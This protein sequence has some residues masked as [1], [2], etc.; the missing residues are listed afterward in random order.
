MLVLKLC[1]SANSSSIMKLL[2]CGSLDNRHH[3]LASRATGVPS[4]GL[5]RS[6]WQKTWNSF[7][8]LFSEC[9]ISS[10]I[11]R[12]FG[13]YQSSS[14]LVRKR[15]ERSSCDSSAVVIKK[16]ESNVTA[17]THEQQ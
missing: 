3:F 12:E 15:S 14:S 8:V 13:L 6:L 5:S 9:V 11:T 10:R 2:L 16:V 7:P 1:A 17:A 4:E